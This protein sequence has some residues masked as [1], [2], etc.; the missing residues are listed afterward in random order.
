MAGVQ[1]P[2]WKACSSARAC[3][4]GCNRRPSASPST[5]VTE[6][7]ATSA[8]DVWQASTGVPSTST[9]HAAHSPSPQPGL[10]PVRPRSDRSTA[11]RVPDGAGLSSRGSPFTM[12][13]VTGLRYGFR[14]AWR[15]EVATE[16][17][18]AARTVKKSLVQ[19][20]RY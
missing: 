13:P 16:P 8:A 3:W 6:R 7:P 5:V 10:V 1:Y 12:I 4:T 15:G 14:E 9:V 20:S 11:R 18:G 19:P 2:H 17:L